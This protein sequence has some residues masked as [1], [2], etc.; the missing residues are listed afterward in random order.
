MA[1]EDI[2]GQVAPLAAVAGVL[3]DQMALDAM[4]EMGIQHYLLAAAVVLMG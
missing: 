3:P 1:T 4:V 2:K